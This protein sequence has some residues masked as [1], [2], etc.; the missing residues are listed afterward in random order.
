MK[1]KCVAVLAALMLAYAA[2]SR[3]NDAA[4]ALVDCD[5]VRQAATDAQTKYI[6]AYTPRVNPVQT[7]DD[8]VTSC[9]ENI[10]NFD[11]G[12]RLPSLLD[13]ESLLNNMM[14]QLMQQVC[15]AATGQ[16]EK[17]VN[18]ATRSVNGSVAGSAGGIV[19]N[20]ATSGRGN[21]GVTVTGDNGATVRNAVSNATD[22]VINFLVP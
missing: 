17:A 22:R 21:T 5:N 8:S 20:P 7:F 4:S 2:P 3:S 13:L 16:F 12:L 18:E 10:S 14:K 1:R 11:I 15:Q 6:E 19:T 9:I